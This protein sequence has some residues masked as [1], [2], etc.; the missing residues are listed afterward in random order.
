MRFDA[1]LFTNLTRDHLDY[2]AD[3]REYFESKA[4]LFLDCHP[5]IASSISI[6]NT[7]RNLLHVRP[8][9]RQRVDES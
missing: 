3:M 1:A 9:R 7:V 8:G 2:H 4:R 5:K 6:Q